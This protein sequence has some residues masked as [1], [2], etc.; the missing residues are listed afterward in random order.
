[1]DADRA[2]MI[3][4]GDVTAILEIRSSPILSRLASSAIEWLKVPSWA[5]LFQ[6]MTFLVAFH[7]SNFTGDEA[8]V[9]IHSHTHHS[10]RCMLPI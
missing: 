9:S 7:W 1:M 2:P 8:Q 10:M 6:P 5:P 3:T 4:D